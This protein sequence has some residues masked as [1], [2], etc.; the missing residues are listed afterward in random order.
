[1]ASPGFFDGM[2]YPL[3]GLRHLA[4]HR[5]LWPYAL[6]ALLV[7]IIVFIVLGVI[8]AALT[9]GMISSEKPGPTVLILGCAAL[10]LGVTGG[11]VVYALVGN[12]IAGPYLEAM[13]EKM[14][15]DAGRL[16]ETPRGFWIAFAS[17]LGDQAGRLLLFLAVQIGFLGMWFTPGAFLH[18]LAA[19]AASVFFVALEPLEYPLEARGL[20]FFERIRWG[21]KRLKPALG[22]GTTLFLIMPLAGFVILPGAV[23]GAVL[24]EQK[25]THAETANASSPANGPNL[26]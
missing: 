24:L 10:L 1:M 18:P 26:N 13:T 16:R 7:G 2:L 20:S 15:A 8:A 22:F 17:G 23:C 25:L 9:L 3:L 21:L 11:I 12:V 5:E 6:K 19:I 14:M 4:R